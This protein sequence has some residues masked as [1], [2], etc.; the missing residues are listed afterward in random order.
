MLTSKEELLLPKV[1]KLMRFVRRSDTSAIN[2]KECLRN[3]FEM[4]LSSTRKEALE[5]QKQ[6]GTISELLTNTEVVSAKL[7]LAV[8]ALNGLKPKNSGRWQRDWT[9]AAN[10]QVK[11][12]AQLEKRSAFRTKEEINLYLLWTITQAVILANATDI[13]DLLQKSV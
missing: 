2:C 12:L 11:H 4:E 10:R 6:A 3:L 8:C 1:F 5:I 13:L 7:S 9:D